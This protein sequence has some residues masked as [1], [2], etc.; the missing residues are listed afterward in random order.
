MR[1]NIQATHERDTEPGEI[2]LAEQHA[3]SEVESHDLEVDQLADAQG[4]LTKLGRTI[5]GTVDMLG[6]AGKLPASPSMRRYLQYTALARH[7]QTEPL[8]KP[9]SFFRASPADASSILS[10]LLNDVKIR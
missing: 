3:L 1:I 4:N 10:T 8:M 7:P 5:V 9:G 6:R 2:D